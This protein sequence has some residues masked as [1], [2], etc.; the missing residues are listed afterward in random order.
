MGSVSAILLAA[1]ESRRMG[2]R[3]KLALIVDGVP[4]IRR[5]ART[6]L[7]SHLAEVVVVLGH[8]ADR[9]RR[10][11]DGLTLTL[12]ENAHYREGQMTSVHAG[13]A[14]LSRPCD[15]FMVCLADQPLLEPGDVDGLTQAFDER[16]RGSVLVPT[17][18]GRRGN[19]VILAC[20]HRE[21]ILSGN[22]KL[23]CRRFIDKN[24]DLVETVEWHNDHVVFDL[25]TPEDYHELSRRVGAGEAIGDT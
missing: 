17:F 20:A 16:T 3:N 24:P 8:E 12:V 9:I 18:K 1:G 14:A 19:P 25:D 7:A 21:A 15:G 6:L 5:T 23:G 13:L 2:D 10:L 22:R 11:L 4:L